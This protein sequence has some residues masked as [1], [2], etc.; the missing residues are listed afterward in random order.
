MSYRTNQ[1]YFYPY[2]KESEKLLK[3]RPPK[4]G[5]LKKP[6]LTT[7]NQCDNNKELYIIQNLKPS[8]SCNCNYVFKK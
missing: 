1:T 6:P 3:P 5:F 8:N 4:L 2:D 7:S